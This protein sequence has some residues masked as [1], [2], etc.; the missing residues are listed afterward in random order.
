MVHGGVAGAL[1]SRA[2]RRTEGRDCT[3]TVTCVKACPLPQPK[4]LIKN[5]CFLEKAEIL[6]S[7]GGGCTRNQGVSDQTREGQRGLQRKRDGGWGNSK[8]MQRRDSANSRGQG[9]GA[10][11][12]GGEEGWRARKIARRRDG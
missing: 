11:E 10:V 1:L 3:K 5:N 8:Q 9:G 7:R 6:Q 4:E 2:L 12:R